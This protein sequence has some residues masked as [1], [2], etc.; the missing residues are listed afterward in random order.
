MLS[1]A[2]TPSGVLLLCLAQNRYQILGV[3][4]MGAQLLH[5]QRCPGYMHVRLASGFVLVGTV[6]EFWVSAVLVAFM[7]V[8]SVSAVLASCMQTAADSLE[9]A[10]EEKNLRHCYSTHE[11][12]R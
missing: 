8:S 12:R 7:C 3:V 6:C 2:V 10:S 4:Q 5:T 11:A 1:S 9:T